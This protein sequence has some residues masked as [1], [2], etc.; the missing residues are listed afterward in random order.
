M[1]VARSFLGELAAQSDA[2]A[3]ITRATWAYSRTHQDQIVVNPIP[4]PS[5]LILFAAGAGLIGLLAKRKT[6]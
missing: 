5:S 6:A 2:R 3:S 1:N 4:E